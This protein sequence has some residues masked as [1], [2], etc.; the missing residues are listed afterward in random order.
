MKPKH[1]VRV[2]L[3]E[4]TT[5]DWQD[6]LAREAFASGSDVPKSWKTE[7]DDGA[8]GCMPAGWYLLGLDADNLPITW[9]TRHEYG[10][11]KSEE[12]E[13]LSFVPDAS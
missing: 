6:R 7:Y 1:I 9:P 12:E 13:A 3:E 5:D 11:F 10:P 2:L 8:D 4:E